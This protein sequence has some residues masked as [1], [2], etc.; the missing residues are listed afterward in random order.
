MNHR[1]SDVRAAVFAR[2][3]SQGHLRAVTATVGVA[4][5]VTAG[6]VAAI[7]PGST[8]ASASSR[9]ASPPAPA[10]P[11]PSSSPAAGAPPPPHPGLRPPG[12][13]AAITATT[14]TPARPP[15]RPPPRPP[16][17]LLRPRPPRRRRACPVAPDL[18]SADRIR[19]SP[20]SGVSCGAPGPSRPGPAGVVAPHPGQQPAL[21]ADLRHELAAPQ[22]PEVPVPPQWPGIH[23]DIPDHPAGPGP[24]R[25]QPEPAF[26]AAGGAG[27][28]GMR[29]VERTGTRTLP[30]RAGRRRPG[31][32]G[33]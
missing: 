11:A 25:A 13:I 1:R 22:A 8:H 20:L 27:C 6:V 26:A 17:C 28:R 19:L 32:R 14:G 3:R 2:R 9:T 18:A 16:R 5:V 4:G 23:Q 31:L 30:A 33:N 29:H 15:R 10:A 7:L 24:V 21:R 12:T